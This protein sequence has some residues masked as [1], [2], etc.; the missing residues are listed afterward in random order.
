MG[1]VVVENT[2]PNGV[3]IGNPAKRTPENPLIITA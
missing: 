2:E 3:Y 1:A